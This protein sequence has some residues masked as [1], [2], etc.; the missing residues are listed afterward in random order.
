MND[1]LREHLLQGRARVGD[2]LR[3][4]SLV[5]ELAL[6]CRDVFAAQFDDGE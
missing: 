3:G 1:R 5:E 4:E 2:G 6:P